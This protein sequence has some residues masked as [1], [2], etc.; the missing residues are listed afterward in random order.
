ML[1]EEHARVFA[2]LADALLPEAEPGAGLGDDVAVDGI[3]DQLA[4]ARDPFVVEDVEL[5]VTEG[6]RDL[7]LHHLHLGTVADRAL[8]FLERGD[9][10]D[11]EPDRGVELE[12]PPA[13]RGLGGVVNDHIVDEIGVVA[14]DLDVEAVRGA[15][16]RLAITLEDLRGDRAQQLHLGQLETDR[17]VPDFLR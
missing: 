14:L 1:L 13:G 8:A 2:A 15:S 12:R 3:V 11:V 16:R 5:G 17:S 7:V 4:L 6:C 9:A 10:A